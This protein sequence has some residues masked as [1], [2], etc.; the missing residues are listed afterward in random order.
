MV[1]RGRHRHPS[2]STSPG[3]CSRKRVHV[4]FSQGKTLLCDIFTNRRGALFF[5]TVRRRRR[6]GH[7]RRHIEVSRDVLLVPIETLAATLATVAH[8]LVFDRD[9][10]IDRDAWRIAIVPCVLRSRSCSRTT[11]IAS[12]YGPHACGSRIA[13]HCR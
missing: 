5:W 1:W 8:L 7:D 11:V 10:A 4:D 2:S 9:A 13:L 12:R 3:D 6:T